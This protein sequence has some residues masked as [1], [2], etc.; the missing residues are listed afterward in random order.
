MKSYPS[1]PSWKSVIGDWAG[2]E[3]F[4]FEK[5][6][7]SNIR[8]EWSRK[9]GWYKFGSRTRLLSESDTT[10]GRAIPVFKHK[11]G[12]AIH[13]ILVKGLKNPESAIVYC[14]FFGPGS[15][16]GNHRMVDKQHMDLVLFDVDIY[17][18]G[19]LPPDQFVDHFGALDIPVLCYRGPLTTAY[20]ENV[21][22]D[23]EELEEGV[24]VKT[25]YKK[26]VD[27]CKIKT[28]FWL[29]RLKTKTGE[30]EDC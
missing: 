29:Q 15:F 1:I 26:Q 10:L 6:D 28:R 3:C 24:V 17:R 16:A 21:K 13:D 12:D 11:Y 14:E 19:L 8:C 23:S 2:L 18:K 22:A 5:I 4:A 25:V 20:V 30:V 27:M 7:G 9:R